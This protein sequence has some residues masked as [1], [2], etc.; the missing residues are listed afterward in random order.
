MSAIPGMLDKSYMDIP[1]SKSWEYLQA[2][3]IFCEVVL[4]AAGWGAK[5]RSIWSMAKAA[6]MVSITYALEACVRAELHRAAALS[7]QK[8]VF[9]LSALEC[10]SIKSLTYLVAG[11]MSHRQA[12]AGSRQFHRAVRNPSRQHDRRSG[13]VGTFF[14][15][16]LVGHLTADSRWR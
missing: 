1:E 9:M 12:P 8:A 3:P 10:T 13:L 6:G 4:G 11:R 15:S 7:T 14:L 2:P 16:S 5:S